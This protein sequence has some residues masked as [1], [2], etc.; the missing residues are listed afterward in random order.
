MFFTSACGFETEDACGYKTVSFNNFDQQWF[1]LS[2][3]DNLIEKGILNWNV[4]ICRELC[5]VLT[6]A[7]FLCEIYFLQSF[8]SFHFM[9]LCY[10]R[11]SGSPIE[12]D[13]TDSIKLGSY[14]FLDINYTDP[15][16]VTRE[17][18]L[19]SPGLAG[20][21]GVFFL[22]LNPSQGLTWRGRTTP[23]SICRPDISWRGAQDT[24]HLWKYLWG[25]PVF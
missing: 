15:E 18:L 10:R 4:V 20:C 3:T 11:K 7:T 23:R 8:A 16:N 19:R 14:Q 25:S 5:P 21:L 1:E 22:L 6:T 24:P 12:S 17:I 9:T 2:I 13:H